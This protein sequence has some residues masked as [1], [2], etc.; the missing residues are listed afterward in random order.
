MPMPSARPGLSLVPGDVLAAMEKI[1]K[2]GFDVWVVG[3]ALRDFL[4]EVE[5]KDWDL[6]TS[7]STGKI[8][9]LFPR[10]IPVGIRHGTVQVHTST[11]DIEVTSFEPSGH[12]GILKDLGRRDFTINSLALSYPDGVLVDPNGGREDLLTGLIRAVGNPRDRFSEDPL[13]IVRAARMRAIY[14]FEVDAGTFAAMR[15]CSGKLESVSGERIRDEILKILPAR[16]VSGAFGLLRKSGAF[17]KLLPCLDEGSHTPAHT[18]SGV[19]IYEHTLSC[20]VNSPERTRV[21]LAALF[22]QIALPADEAAPE[23]LPSNFRRESSR[24]A[25]VIMKWWNMSN[26]NIDEVSS[27]VL[28]QL[29][30]EAISWS[31]IRIRQFITTVNPALLADF[32]ALAEAEILSEGYPG[33]LEETQSRIEGIR[34]LGDRMR[35]QLE[36]LSAS[37]V[38]ELAL[39]GDDI[40]KILD[41]PPGPEVGRV[42]RHLFDLVL[43]NPDI[44]TRERLSRIVETEKNRG[45]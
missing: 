19:G 15:E 22:H 29:P 32:T 3:G 36:R 39:S 26:R 20:I 9:S 42:L 31:D 45:N 24:S 44:N 10:V 23:G 35:V 25:R 7:A 28:H 4:L 38:R 43:K 33:A 16:D 40:I 1:H 8:S 17:G 2:A 6:A 12:A 37:N 27:L 34:R 5:P 18:G 11:R 41:I 21:R 13:R 14:G 30:L